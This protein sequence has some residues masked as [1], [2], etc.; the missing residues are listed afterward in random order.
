MKFPL[1]LRFS[2]PASLLLFG[3]LLGGLSFLYDVNTSF[4]RIESDVN[5]RAS[6][7]GNQMASALQHHLRKGDMEGAALQVS[8]AGAN[9]NLRITAVSDDSGRVVF[10]TRHHLRNQALPSIAHPSARQS[11]E[12]AKENRL[13]QFV[14]TSDRKTLLGIFPFLLPPEPGELLSSKTGLLYLEYDL[15]LL[16]GIDFAETTRRSA[17]I[18]GVLIFCFVLIW[19]FFHRTLTLRVTQ[20]LQATQRLAKG[21]FSARAELQGS[22]ELAALSKSFDQ[23]AVNIRART[24]ELELANQKMRREIQEREHAENRFLSVWKSSADG[25]RLTDQSGNIVAVNDAFCSIVGMTPEELEGKP[26]TNCYADADRTAEMMQK[27]QDRFANRHISSILDREV[28][29]HTGKN[30]ALEV[31]SSFIAQD[32]QEPLLLSIFRNVTERKRAEELLNQQAASMEASIDGMA[33]LNAEGNYIFVNDAHAKIYGY[34]TPEELIGESWEL[35]YEGDELCRFKEYIMPMTWK[36]G[37]WRGEAVGRR[38]DGGA[39]PQEISLSTIEGGGLVCVIRDMTERKTEEERR[40]AIDRKLQDAQKLE[41][42]GVLAGGIAHDFNNLLTAIIGNANLAMMKTPE[43]SPL[44]SYLFNV[45]KTSMQAADLCKQMLAYSGRGKFVIQA[46]QMCSLIKDMIP[47]LQISVHKRVTLNFNLADSLPPIEA[48]P[49]QMRQVVMNLVINAS[50]AV[51]ENNGTV[52]V[53]TGVI[54]VDQAY[55]SEYYSAPELTAGN[56]I[57]VEVSDTGCGMNAETRAKIFEP[58]FTTKFT[59][60]GLGLA[61]VLGIIR[62]HKGA[63]KVYSEPGQGTA[64][65]FL[66]P[67]E[68]TAIQHLPAEFPNA[69]TWR[70]SGTVLVVDDEELVRMVTAQLLENFGFDVLTAGDGREGVEQ[71]RMHADKIS[72][73]VLDMTMPNMNGEEAFLEIRKLQPEARVLL[74]SGYSE[75]EATTRF[76]GKGLAGFLQKPFTADDLR[77]K[78]RSVLEDSPI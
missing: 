50:E 45:E 12:A 54:E 78:M 52:T 2:I 3:F 73:V 65:K 14:T 51:G 71:F 29:F 9:S 70:G 33:I 22:D 72:A 67:C 5:R 49:S 77:R 63:I 17:I 4:Q 38:H 34:E 59:G 62:G 75:Q 41:S 20:L 36:N 43:D 35:L 42:L 60:R 39:F 68:E 8:L 27:Y 56:Y 31:T 13:A 23:M 32:N 11:I 1:P 58:F 47:L 24:E 6:F 7:L 30:A 16:K 53:N 28:T 25:M 44:R 37:L 46:I 74:I 48:D 21:D 61:A 40:Q 64:F 55:L 26:F 15:A 18:A 76:A 66:I 10:S 69:S 19:T 57:S